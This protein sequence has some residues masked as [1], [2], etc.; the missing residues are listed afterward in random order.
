MT[1]L[2]QV[3]REVVRESAKHSLKIAWAQIKQFK[4]ENNE[5][6]K[7]S[8]QAKKLVTLFN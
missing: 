1:Q 4:R 7:R 2:T 5:R 6:A 8:V 3:Q